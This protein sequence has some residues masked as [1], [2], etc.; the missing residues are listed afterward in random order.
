MWTHPPQGFC[1]IWENKRTNLGQKAIFGV[2]WVLFEVFGPC[3]GINH[4]THP[5]LGKLSQIKPNFWGAPLIVICHWLYNDSHWLYNLALGIGNTGHWDLGV[6]WEGHLQQPEQA[7]QHCS[8]PSLHLHMGW[9]YHLHHWLVLVHPIWQS[10]IHVLAP[11]GALVFIMVYY[12]PSK[13]TFPNFSN[14]EQSCPYTFLIHFHF[15]P[16]FNIQNRTRHYFCMNYIDNAY[17]YNF[18][19]ILQGSSD[20]S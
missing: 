18:F 12:I 1:E 15:H 17:M 3:L 11:S 2:I 16:V 4:P 14:L 19:K 9:S 6:V 5:H 7:D 10:F 8:W 20:F 13:P